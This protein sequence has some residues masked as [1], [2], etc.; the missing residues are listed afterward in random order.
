MMRKW[1]STFALAAALGFE[2]SVPAAE[3]PFKDRQGHTPIVY[4]GTVTTNVV[5]FPIKVVYAGLGGLVGGMAYLVTAGDTQAFWSIW[6]AAAGGSYFVT[7]SMLE[8]KEDVRF[9]GP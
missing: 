6:D 8:G 3:E 4:V 7:P 9:R 1:L 5:Y 2:G